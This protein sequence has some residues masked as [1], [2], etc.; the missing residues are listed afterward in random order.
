IAAAQDAQHATGQAAEQADTPAVAPASSADATAGPASDSATDSAAGSASGVP[1]GQS[2]EDPDTGF[3]VP[4]E[5]ASPCP[6]GDGTQQPI[7]DTVHADE[8]DGSAS[9]ATKC[10]NPDCSI[11][12]GHDWTP[13]DAEYEQYFGHP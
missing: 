7:P 11:S 5:A 1:A 8:G 6:C 10:D 13:T 9:I 3:T 4:A 12:S 2:W